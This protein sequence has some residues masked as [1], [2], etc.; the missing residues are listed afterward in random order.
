MWVLT[1]IYFL[2]KRFDGMIIFSMGGNDLGH[3]QSN[4]PW[5]RFSFY[6]IKMI[7]MGSLNFL[8]CICNNVVLSLVI[9][10]FILIGKYSFNRVNPLLY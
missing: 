5:N 6:N 3:D 1:F 8:S 2:K 9:I 10:T 7:W 4:Y